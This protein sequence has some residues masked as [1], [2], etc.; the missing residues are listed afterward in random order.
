M[1]IS[2]C[3]DRPLS[4]LD[5]M[6]VEVP[7]ARPRGRMTAE[8]QLERMKRH[9]RAL[10]R[11]RKRNLSQGERSITSQ[12]SSSADPPTTVRY[13]SP[14]RRHREPPLHHSCCYATLQSP[15]AQ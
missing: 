5:P 9:Q 6:D 7:S 14:P 3:Q 4:A 1:F 11:E 2:W 15:A 10:V 12:R 13:P 8:E